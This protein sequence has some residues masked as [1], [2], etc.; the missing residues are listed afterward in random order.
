MA[1]SDFL[2]EKAEA[3]LEDAEYDIS[4]KNGFWPL[5]I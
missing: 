4:R 2:K 5:S 1:K 3:F